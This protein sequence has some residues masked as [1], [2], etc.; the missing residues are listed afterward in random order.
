MKQINHIHDILRTASDELAR[1]KAIKRLNYL[2]LRLQAL[3]PTSA[4]WEDMR[5]AARLTDKLTR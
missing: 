5:Y 2:Q 3:H 4:L 1:Y